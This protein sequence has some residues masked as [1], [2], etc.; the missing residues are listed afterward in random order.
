[1]APITKRM[2]ENSN[3]EI[4]ASKG[5]DMSSIL[6]LINE[7]FKEQAELIASKMSQSEERILSLLHERLDS[8]SKEMQE[9][10]ERVQQLE[11]DA[12][13]VEALKTQVGLLES[14]LSTL[15]TAEVAN[16]LRMHGVPFTEGES[17]KTIFNSLC[18]SLGIT[19]APKLKDICRIRQAKTA[20][21]VVDPTIIIKLENARDK[22][23]LIR[24]AGEYR[25]TTKQLLNLQLLGFDSCTPIYLNEQLTKE[26]YAVFKE[27]MQMKRKRILTAVFCRRGCVYVKQ[28]EKSEPMCV[29]SF[30]KLLQ[31]QA[32]SSTISANAPPE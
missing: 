26:T 25:R 29:E 32:E 16:D 24:A 28:C 23:A 14:K 7:R 18:F 1:M 10:C 21:T 12:S 11:R 30:Q 9:L 19:P 17:L 5:M 27:A 22:I 20:N 15:A 3:A 8:M 13:V 4:K 2:R 31:L 6:Q